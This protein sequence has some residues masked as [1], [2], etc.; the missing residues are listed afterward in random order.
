MFRLTR[1]GQSDR[2]IQLLKQSKFG[3]E[4]HLKFCNKSK[5]F[6]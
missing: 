5:N 4:K 3:I 2:S 1:N 6:E